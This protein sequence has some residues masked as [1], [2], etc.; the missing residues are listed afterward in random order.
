[1]QAFVRIAAAF[2]IASMAAGAHASSQPKPPAPVAISP[3]FDARTF[4]NTYCITC[5][6]QRAKTAGVMFDTL[7]LAKVPADA[8]VWEKAIRK[9]RVGMMPPQGA[10]RPDAAVSHALLSWLE[11]RLDAAAAASPNPGRP[12][13]H[14]LNRAEYGNAIRDLLALEVDATSL[15][16][17]DDSGYGFDNIADTLGVTPVLLERYLTAAD[18]I[19]ALAV[20]DPEITPGSETFM[21]RQDAS[22]DRH[23]EGLPVGTVGGGLA[24]T[25]L[26]LDGE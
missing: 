24:R 9:V 15:L 6:N 13:V 8:E 3:T 7:D 4:L 19:S 17:P 2:W 16:P 23:I 22:Q 20:G 18:R 11:T 5:H 14:R 1:M 21:I 10:P 26:P 12:L 25:T